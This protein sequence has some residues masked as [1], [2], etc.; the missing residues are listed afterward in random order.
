MA[1]TKTITLHQ[2]LTQPTGE[3]GAGFFAARFRYREALDSV[4]I[5]DLRYHR[6]QFS[7]TP[8]VD[9]K[10]LTG[11]PGNLIFW[12]F[13]PSEN[14]DFNKII[15]SIVFL[16]EYDPKRSIADRDM[17][18]FSNDPDW[19]FRY[20]YVF[21]KDDLIPDFMLPKLPMECKKQS[22]HITNPEEI[23]GFSKKSYEAMRY[24]QI[25]NCLTDKYISKYG[26]ELTPMDTARIMAGT[27]NTERIV[28]LYQDA[29]HLEAIKNKTA[30][31]AATIRDKVEIK[32]EQQTYKDY[33]RN[34]APNFVGAIF[35]HP[36]RA[37]MTAHSAVKI[38]Q[39]NGSTGVRMVKPQLPTTKY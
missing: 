27:A 15:Y 2:M 12:V 3:K 4:W 6:Q 22:P 24:L 30:K 29:K 34:T 19:I 25:G 5:R 21:Y 23:R 39:K 7:A 20:S 16:F 14:Y 36:A 17:K 8:F 32:K 35:K 9:T 10:G 33:M 38:I 28:K 11:T 13:V 31:S 26:R 37:D 18:L 1:Q